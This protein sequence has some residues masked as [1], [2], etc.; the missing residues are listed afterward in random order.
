MSESALPPPHVSQS[1]IK[2]LALAWFLMLSPA[3]RERLLKILRLVAAAF[4]GPVKSWP[5]DFGRP[6]YEV[7]E[8]IQANREGAVWLRRLAEQLETVENRLV[9]HP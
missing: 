2:M 7:E 8:V 9:N 1:I 6:M 4:S 5:L 3:E